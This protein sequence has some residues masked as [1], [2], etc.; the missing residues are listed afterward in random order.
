MTIIGFYPNVQLLI[1]ELQKANGKE[2]AYELIT[3]I[4]DVYEQNASTAWL[5]ADAF[6]YWLSLI[7]WSSSCM[8]AACASGL[9]SMYSTGTSIRGR[10]GLVSSSLSNRI[11]INTPR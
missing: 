7:H 1:R 2:K 4:C 3:Q 9:L 8:K 10:E 11:F 6:C 5:L